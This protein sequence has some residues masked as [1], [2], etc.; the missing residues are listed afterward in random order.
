[1]ALAEGTIC[2]VTT[3]LFRVSFTG[4]LGFEINVPSDYGQAV[5]EAVYA[6][7][8]P[9]GI[10]PYGTESMHVL[11]AEKGFII[12]GQ[13]TDGTVTPDDAGLTWAVGKA[14]PDFVGKRSLSRSGMMDANRKQLVGLMSADNVTVLEE[15]V[16]IVA[17]PNQ[18]VPMSV[19]GHVTSSYLS[20]SL[21]HPIA[22]ALLAGGRAR[23][24]ETLHVPMPGGR[25]IA[26]QVV[27][28]VFYD[29]EGTRLNG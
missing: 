27:P 29:P 20:P 2:G 9:H 8:I 14:K 18:P 13:E 15:G 23:H 12:V 6:A 22:L 11:R 4:E 10:T 1:M 24:G 28:P 5:W 3:R 16:Q 25:S 17:D 19:L 7:G 26:V 21:G